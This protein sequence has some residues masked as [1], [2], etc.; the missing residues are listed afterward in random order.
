MASTVA[1]A[2]VVVLGYCS[3]SFSIPLFD[4]PET[5]TAH[6]PSAPN[7]LLCHT[8]LRLVSSSLHAHVRVLRTGLCRNE[9]LIVWSC[10]KEQS[11]NLNI[12][13]C[14]VLTEIILML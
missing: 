2:S 8:F 14:E 4:I 9:P 12:E 5:I 3:N 13:V 11:S 7:V 1:V 6:V 10:E